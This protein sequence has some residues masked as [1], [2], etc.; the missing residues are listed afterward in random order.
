MN[1]ATT[2]AARTVDTRPA[3]VGAGPTRSRTAVATRPDER[4]VQLELVIPALNEEDRLGPSLAAVCEHLAT[5]PFSTRVLVVD[6]GSVDATAATAAAADGAEVPVR[7]I[8]CRD[9]GKGAAVRAGMKAARGRWVGF[10]DADLAT[11]IGAVDDVI[12]Q[13]DAGAPVVIGSRRCIGASFTQEQ[14]ALRRAGGWAFRRLTRDI[15]PGIA[16]TQCGFKFF[17]AEAA[18]ALFRDI[19]SDGFS[20]DLELLAAAA[21]QGVPVVEVP[22]AW[23]DRDGSSLRPVEHG[24]EVLREVR[25][26]RQL[27]AAEKTRDAVPA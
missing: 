25:H 27:A 18:E 3:R 10:C 16:D 8:G 13:L 6:N 21:R 23:T 4:T 12:V 5:L 22:V 19:D 1:G 17:T 9:R 11:P 14:P 20:F 15:V 7:V 2:T 26:L 24:R